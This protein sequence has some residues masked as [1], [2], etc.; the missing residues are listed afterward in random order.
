MLDEEYC[1]LPSIP[2]A[3]ET[4]VGNPAS[5]LPFSPAHSRLPP[6]RTPPSGSV[7]PEVPRRLTPTRTA[8]PPPLVGATAHNIPNFVSYEQDEGRGPGDGSGDDAGEG[9]WSCNRC[10]YD[11]HPAMSSCEICGA[12]R[13][14]GSS[15]L[16][17]PPPRSGGGG[18]GNSSSSTAGHQQNQQAPL[19][20]PMQDIHIR[21]RH[22]H[23]YPGSTPTLRA[24]ST[25]PKPLKSFD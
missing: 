17:Q 4:G 2:G 23:D 25:Q 18:G 11:N 16:Q 7:R 8:P 5:Q 12:I 24:Q 9:R 10:T 6:N 14:P 3:R 21:V 13:M 1:P 20:P 22:R 15:P 19:G